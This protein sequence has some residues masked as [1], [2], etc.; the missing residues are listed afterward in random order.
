MN[1]SFENQILFRHDQSFAPHTPA[2]IFCRDELDVGPSR[3]FPVFYR[4]VFEPTHNTVLFCICFLFFW[5][6]KLFFFFLSN[7]FTRNRKV[8]S[9]IQEIL[10]MSCL[11]S[12]CFVDAP[13][14]LDVVV[15]V[16]YRYSSTINIRKVIIYVSTYICMRVCI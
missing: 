7:T 15:Y 9:T 12:S 13:W 11:R 5:T 16:S 3:S 14:F 4:E 2:H 1:F 8:G 10:F 6:V